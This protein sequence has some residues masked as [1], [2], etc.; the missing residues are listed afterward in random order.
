M[1]NRRASSCDPAPRIWDFA[2]RRIEVNALE[3][4]GDRLLMPLGQSE[5]LEARAVF[6]LLNPRASA[7]GC[8]EITEMRETAA[9]TR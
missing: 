8:A 2:P 6:G 9:A 1:G 7:L 4:G 5:H 3:D